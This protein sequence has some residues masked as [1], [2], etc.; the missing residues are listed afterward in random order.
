MKKHLA[1]IKEKTSGM[2]R[3]ETCAYIMAY[4]WYHILGAVMAIAL[5]LL[6]AVH[7]GFG[8]QKPVFT[9]LIVNQ[10]ADGARDLQIRDGFAQ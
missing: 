6:F 2:G 9:C 5:I 10:A 8:N 1:D 3:R 4:Y 7:Y